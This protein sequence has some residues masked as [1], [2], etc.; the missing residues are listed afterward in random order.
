MGLQQDKAQV[1]VEQGKQQLQWSLWSIALQSFER[2]IAIDQNSLHA[3]E[4]NAESL[5]RLKKWNEVVEVGQRIVELRILNV[6]LNSDFYSDQGHS[7]HN[8]QK[9]AAALESYQKCLEI[10][11]QNNIAWNGLGNAL[12]DLAKYEEAVESYQRC[13]EINPHY[14]HAWNGL[15]NA[16]QGI[17]K[18]EEAIE[19][20][21][22]CLEINPQYDYAWNGLGN[23]LQGIAKY[24]EAFESYQKCLEINPQYDKAWN[25]LGNAIRSLGEYEE[26]IDSYQKCLEINSRND[27]AWNGQG[28][29]LW[30]LERYESAVESYEKCMEINPQYYYDWNDLG[31]SLRDLKKYETAI[32]LYQKCLEINPQ[33]DYAWNGLGNVLRD[34]ERNEA[35]INSYREC[36]KINPRNDN[37]WNGLGN[38]LQDLG[39]YEEAV[40]S[41][42]KC[43]E[44][45]PQA[46]NA[47]NGLG[48]VFWD[49][50]NCVKALESYNQ[51]L[52]LNSQNYNAWNGRGNALRD[53]KRYEEAL[54][55]YNKALEINPQ[56]DLA[57]NG[58][59]NALKDLKRCEEA[60]ESY[61]KALEIDP[62]NEYAWNGRGN[63]LMDLERYEASID[64]Y[65]R[66]TLINPNDWLAWTN[67]AECICR[68]SCSYIPR[69]DFDGFLRSE[70]TP[71]LRSPNPHIAAFQ[72]AILQ[73]QK[74]TKDWGKIH[75]NL[76]ETYI[77]HENSRNQREYRREAI[78]CYQIALQCLP[79]ET[80][81]DD[82]LAVL[83]AL[84]RVCLKTKQIS[85]A[86]QY[87]TQGSQLY[88]TLRTQAQ[89]RRTFEAKF[90]TF[91]LTEI[92]L[93][94]GENESRLA[95]T[96]AEFYKNRALNWLFD[97][98]QEITHSPTY[99][100]I[101]SKLTPE[102]AIVYWHQSTDRITTFILTNDNAEPIVLDCDRQQQ[103]KRFI[104]WKDK[105]DKDYNDY[106]SK[107][108]TT[109]SDHP[110]RQKMRDRVKQLAE[111]LEIDTIERHLKNTETLILIPHRDLH[112]YP[113]H[114]LFD[115]PTTHAPSL[116]SVVRASHPAPSSDRPSLLLI[117]DPDRSSRRPD[118]RPMP[119]AQIESAIIQ[120][121]IDRN[122]THINHTN[123]TYINHTNATHDTIVQQLTQQNHH[124]FHFI[125][126]AEHDFQKPENSALDLCDR[127]LTAKTIANLNLHHLHL[128]TLSSCE[129]SIV[130][131]ENHAEYLGLT[132]AFL[133]AGTHN[134]L[135]TL[136]QVEEIASA[137]FMIHFHQL[138][139]AG[140]SPATALCHTQI[141]MQ[142]VT[143]RE[144]THWLEHLRQL[145]G[146][147]S[148]PIDRLESRI[149]NILNK[150]DTID[151]NQPTEYCDPIHW[152]AFILTGQG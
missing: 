147:P 124:Y 44:I 136:W 119:F 134:I 104:V 53:L 20:Y 23:T 131:T 88:E 132:S 127:P 125:G 1:L 19:S 76:G 21:R 78:R 116:Q 14:D 72:E 121:L 3:W 115:R 100:R 39:R 103:Y 86:R 82:N 35:A 60:L 29:A 37:A 109:Q 73:C 71:A 146:L 129:T 34:I 36:L 7:R 107:K 43:L 89:D 31:N 56:N 46:Y 63:A 17:A 130:S 26:A 138:I 2:A 42:E 66:A 150:G 48:N 91:R 143:W 137:W 69:S 61:N 74:D 135:S 133:C 87:Q 13:L 151:L 16:L 96:Q 33:N 83:H 64:S 68:F 95:V 18:Y 99:D 120:Q 106:R 62:Q 8:A 111:I 84:I 105:W 101:R 110:W 75:Q 114:V 123:A 67:R 79:V 57:W 92:D 93:L 59:G 27:N 54:E 22:R 81:P 126:H 4:G 50:S 6:K 15:G 30:S 51:S 45:N 9:Y 70:K 25:G 40:E 113:I 94:I 152:A 118:H 139:K 128:V 117:D 32:K 10:N 49:L 149:Q 144:F 112:R 97:N 28:L 80:H 47:W 11:P 58:R 90:S 65:D 12:Q 108:L 145:P 140:L 102:T 5:R 55:S 141:W 24:E 41:Y 38:V 122:A 148:F 98:E 77:R 142:T 85:L 52:S